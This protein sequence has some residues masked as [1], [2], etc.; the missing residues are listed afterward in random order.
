M[1]THYKRFSLDT[2]YNEDIVKS[3]VNVTRNA[4]SHKH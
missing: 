4:I 3:T 1:F 2:Y